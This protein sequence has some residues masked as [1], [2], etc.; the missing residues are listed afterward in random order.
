MA[1]TDVRVVVPRV[2]RALENAGAPSSLSDDDIKD[3]VADAIADVILYTG[4][5]FGKEL[6]VK[7]TDEDGV[8]T[9]YETSDALSLPEQSVIA[10]QAAL[11]YFFH[12]FSNLKVQERIADE[13]QEWEYTLSANLIRDALKALIDQRDKALEA[14]GRAGMALERYESFIAVRDAH[15]AAYIEPWVHGAGVGGQDYRFG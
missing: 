8:P 15:V 11:N 5:A 3:R 4:S 14:L 7:D 13:G 10:A 1:A 2:R 9:E 6:V 12:G